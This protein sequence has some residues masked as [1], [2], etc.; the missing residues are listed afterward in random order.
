MVASTSPLAG[1]AAD[2][3]P[4]ASRTPFAS[5]GSD[6]A[7]RRSIETSLI[8]PDWRK[9]A[10]RKRSSALPWRVILGAGLLAAVLGAWSFPAPAEAQQLSADRQ[11]GSS[12]APA[13][14][15]PVPVPL[16]MTAADS[17]QTQQ[18]PPQTSM[19]VTPGTATPA[20]MASGRVAPGTLLPG[21]GREPKPG[22]IQA[23]QVQTRQSPDFIAFWKRFKQAVAADDRAALLAMTHLPFDLEDGNSYDAAQFDKIHEQIYDARARTCLSSRLPVPDDED[24]DV[25]CGDTIYIFGT[26]PDL[27][28]DRAAAAD[29]SGWRLLETSSND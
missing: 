24:Y 6:H 5:P 7:A 4:V 15:T 22:Q 26:E 29:G 14:A 27:M 2:P 9:R 17:S 21:G 16:Q 12:L 25:F 11:L 10:R 19:A 23:L 28:P 3:A 18:M 13:A 20:S 1:A 8:A